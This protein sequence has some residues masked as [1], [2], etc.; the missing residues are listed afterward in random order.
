MTEKRN[1]VLDA[2]QMC[3]RSEAHKYLKEMFDFPD[4]YGANLDALHDCLTELG[5]TE[6]TFLNED[7]GGDFFK[8]VLRVFRDSADEN[9]NLVIRKEEE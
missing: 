2:A 1:L 5:P 6:V 8:K 4:Y 9:P 3:M 7:K